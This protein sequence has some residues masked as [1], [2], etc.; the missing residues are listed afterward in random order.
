MSGKDQ[1]LSQL[2]E[3]LIAVGFKAS[4]TRAMATIRRLSGPLLPG[5][6]SPESGTFPVMEL[7]RGRNIP[8][9]S[10]SNQ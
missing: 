5:E 9:F 4:G 3:P 2:S 8:L 6:L 10:C 1:G 7:T